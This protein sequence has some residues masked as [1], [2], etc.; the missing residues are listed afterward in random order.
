M[1]CRGRLRGFPEGAP[2][3]GGPTKKQAHRP[4]DAPAALPTPAVQ[5]GQGG[6][7][8]PERGRGPRKRGAGTQNGPPWGRAACI[9]PKSTQGGIP[10]GGTSDG[11]A[12]DDILM[13]A[14]QR[15]EGAG[16]AIGL[17]VVHRR[18]PGLPTGHAAAATADRPA[19]A[20]RAVGGG[21][22]G[23]GG[24]GGAAHHDAGSLGADIAGAGGLLRT[25]GLA[26]ALA[27]LRWG[28]EA[29][30]VTGGLVPACGLA[31]AVL[32]SSRLA[33]SAAWGATRTSENRASRTSRM[34]MIFPDC[35]ARP[36]GFDAP[37]TQRGSPLDPK[38]LPAPNRRRAAWPVNALC[39]RASP[40]FGYCR[41]ARPSQSWLC[42]SFS[43]DAVRANMAA[44]SPC[45]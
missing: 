36:R 38:P 24:G 21:V 30:R 33:A 2:T 1:C 45:S 17:G 23:H 22:A 25:G 43:R 44:L 32:G 19:V 8:A 39:P 20:A 31:L 35:V 9:I 16:G 29:G 10:V 7:S 14:G 41:W 3:A 5:R 34:R 28:A 15:R 27:L 26:G 6:V 42:I 18:Q 12:A 4:L 13:P 11:H 40:D 37:S